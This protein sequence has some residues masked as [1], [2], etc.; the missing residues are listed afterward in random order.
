M[1]QQ[2]KFELSGDAG[3]PAFP[4]AM[5]GQGGN[6]FPRGV[7]PPAHG[8]SFA[9]CLLLA[10]AIGGVFGQT[11]RYEFV[12]YD[13]DLYIYENPAV[14]QGLDLREI[15]WMFTHNYALDEWYPL[16]DI[17]HMLDWQIY[18]SNAGGHH[19][20]NVLL[21]AATAILLFLVLQK[22][23]GARW[24]SA[25]VAALFAIHPLRVESVAWA[26][27]RK[28][29]LS[30]VFFMLALWMWV[31]YVQKRATAADG[32]LNLNRALRALDPRRWTA[33]YS[34]AL[35]CFALG[36]MS[37]SMVVTLPFILLLLDYWPL[38][39]FSAS[40][41]GGPRPQMRIWL[42]LILEKTPFLL[43]SAAA[44][45][46]TVLT[47]K[48]V[49]LAAQGLTFLG[50]VGNA[51]TAC[52]VYVGHMVYPV[53]LRLI[54]PAPE[55]H[56]SIWNAG[57][58]ALV[59]VI[60][61]MCVLAGRRKYPWLLVGWLWY[62]GMLVPVIDIMQAG[63]QARADRYTYLPQIGLA[64]LAAWGAVELAG[65]W[66]HRR[67]VL[68]FAA[69]VLL[70]GLMTGAYLQTG[71]WKNSVTLWTR[72]LVFTPQSPVANCNLG[73]A[74][75]AQG[76]LAEA[77]GHFD[78]VLQVEPNNTKA[79]NNIG[80]VLTTEGKLDQAVQRFY[81]VLQ[82]NPDDVKAHNN[83]GVALVAQGKA[84]DAIRHYNRALQL[85]PDDVDA[86]YN[87]GNALTTQGRFDEAVQYYERTLQI[88]PGFAEAHCNLG[89]VLARLGR[90][91]DAVQHYLEAVQLKP[92]Y[93]D[94]LG[95]LGGALAAL[96][97][98]DEAIQHFNRAL[99]INQDDASTHNNLGIALAGQ[100]KMDEAM[101]HFQRALELAEDGNKPV[102]AASIRARLKFYQSASAP[103]T[104]PV[105][106]QTGFP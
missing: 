26:E 81:Q 19:L 60:I 6:P 10:L 35:A 40:G 46:V 24:R 71:Y 15:A 45:G 5:P 1:S 106:A 56:L 32:E 65:S 80:K 72:T 53:G 34:L 75:A 79:L 77:L 36:L 48:E 3:N 31:R 21:H 44:C 52:V 51:L 90:L 105:Q 73:I 27:E 74:L 83:L 7:Q 29:V 4:V 57:L 14:T 43:L 25:F 20:T 41:L 47:Q 11:L 17:S 69:G 67:T 33:D 85:K 30:G 89:L 70:T 2:S 28:D 95:N 76:K 9:I 37:K 84:D 96:G 66:R 92:N 22:M 16:T 18:G 86:C 88:N 13:D 39:R 100:G 62:L 103:A 99:E 78:R 42:G 91:D 12:N 58:S 102:L 49:I 54:Y 93:A 104:S 63:D 64:I 97:R 68:G 55:K 8:I 98:L 101:P 61:S 59:L 38:N 82:I 94:A 50:R 23:T 87:F